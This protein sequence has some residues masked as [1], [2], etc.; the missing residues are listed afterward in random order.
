MN[1]YLSEL[2]IIITGHQSLVKENGLVVINPWCVV[3]IIGVG[4]KRSLALLLHRLS[5]IQKLGF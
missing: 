3:L 1:F 4:I 5:F 2:I